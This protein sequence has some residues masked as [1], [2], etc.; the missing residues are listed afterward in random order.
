MITPDLPGIDHLNVNSNI[1][2]YWA[3]FLGQMISHRKEK[4]FLVGHSRGGMIASQIAEYMPEN[5][6]KLIYLAAFLIPNGGTLLGTLQ[7][8]PRIAGRPPELI[9]SPDQSH[10]KI[11]P[12]AISSKFYNMTAD[13]WIKKAELQ[14]GWEPMISFSTPLSLT[15]KNFGKIPRTYIE[16]LQDRTI[17][18]A[19]QRKMVSVLPC[20]QVFT[21]DTDHS[22]FYSASEELVAKLQMAVST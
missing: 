12:E 22:P 1:L 9:F 3:R 2:E 14:L 19:L 7:Q 8:N 17:P 15:E 13:T 21:L 16:C 18:I 5:I 6:H 4:V 20:E 10:S 11:A